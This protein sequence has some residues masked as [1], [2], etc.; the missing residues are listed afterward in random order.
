MRDW[1]AHNWFWVVL[2]GVF[3]SMHLSGHGGC[4]GGHRAHK[5]SAD[6]ADTP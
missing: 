4:C 1:L 5:S 3:I 6:T 2:A